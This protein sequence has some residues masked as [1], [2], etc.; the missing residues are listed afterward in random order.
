MSRSSERRKRQRL[1]EGRVEKR[2]AT[3][4]P[5]H[6]VSS[7]H[8]HVPERTFT[9]N[10]SPHGAR[11]I[12]QRSWCSGEEAVIVP[13]GGFAQVGRVV[14]CGAQTSGRF[15]LGVEFRGLSIKW[16]EDPRT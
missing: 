5:V 2:L 3:S 10:V 11:I 9:E 16:G 13:R 12:S 7:S 4:V 6:L 1:F 8:A 14:Y 15:C